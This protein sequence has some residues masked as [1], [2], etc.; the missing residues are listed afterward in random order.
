ML[1]RKK[2]EF[3]DSLLL[4]MEVTENHCSPHQTDEKDCLALKKTMLKD[5]KSH[6]NEGSTPYV[7]LPSFS[8]LVSEIEML[9]DDAL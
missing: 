7:T 5:S 2:N 4:A 9:L 1:E 3:R 6:D 8:V